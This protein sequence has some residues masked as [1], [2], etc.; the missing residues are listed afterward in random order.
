MAFPQVDGL[1]ITDVSGVILYLFSLS[2]IIKAIPMVSICGVSVSE[3]VLYG[4][5]I[6]TVSVT[7]CEKFGTPTQVGCEGEQDQT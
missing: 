6:S 3:M 7:A 4:N 5:F 1:S 2:N